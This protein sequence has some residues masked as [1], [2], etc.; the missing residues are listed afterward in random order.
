MEERGDSQKLRQLHV[1]FASSS[2]YLEYF[3]Q[4]MVSN[5]RQQTRQAIN[6]REEAVVADPEMD[7]RTAIVTRRE[8]TTHTEREVVYIVLSMLAPPL[9]RMH[10]V[11]PF[12][13]W[14]LSAGPV[15]FDKHPWLSVLTRWLVRFWLTGWIT[16]ESSLL[17]GARV[18]SVCQLSSPVP[19][20]QQGMDGP[21]QENEG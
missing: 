15:T 20:G 10:K 3:F 17:N 2:G 12:E 13:P 1:K 7:P 4:M 16:P 21:A 18:V 9:P 14:R 8:Q 11:L 19:V 5:R 6:K